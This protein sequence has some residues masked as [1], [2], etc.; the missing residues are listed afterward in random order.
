[1]STE[2]PWEL[3][4]WTRMKDG[5][6][7]MIGR[8]EFVRLLFEAAGVPYIDHGIKDP[9]S[10]AHFV[11]G[12]GNTG[13]PVFAPPVV[14]KGDFVIFNTPAIMRY[15]GR[16]V[17]LFPE[18]PEDAAHADAVIEVITDFMTEGRLVFHPKCFTTT[19]YEQVEESKPY[20]AWFEEHRISKFLGYL[21]RVL[22]ANHA[23]DFTVG[24]KLT[25]VDVALFHVLDAAQ[26]QFPHAFDKAVIDFASLQPFMAKIR[27]L[28]NVAAYLASDRRGS[29]E[30]NSMM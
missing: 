21:D 7:T 1:M 4:Y 10:I 26:S 5:Q 18:T 20:V 28:P 29:Y 25:Y 13:F 30:G 6:N 3:Y 8:G 14:K 22:K 11:Y 24:A 27:A 15:V 2:A 23:S 16:E 19:Y 17:G 9:S 12:G